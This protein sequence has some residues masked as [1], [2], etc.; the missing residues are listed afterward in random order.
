VFLA[1][2]PPLATTGATFER[3]FL[4]VGTARCASAPTVFERVDGN[5][6]LATLVSDTAG[7]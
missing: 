4:D 6:A 2:A 5:L 7:T 1:P 3:V